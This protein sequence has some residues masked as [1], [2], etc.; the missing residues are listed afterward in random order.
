MVC[1]ERAVGL[2]LAEVFCECWRMKLG[3]WRNGAGGGKQMSA[4]GLQ[5]GKVHGGGVS[6]MVNAF[7]LLATG[8]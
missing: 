6:F 7:Q 2:H 3:Y 1:E 8:K 4:V 5:V